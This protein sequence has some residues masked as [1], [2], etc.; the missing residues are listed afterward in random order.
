MQAVTDIE[1][2]STEDKPAI[3]RR[4]AVRFTLL[5]LLVLTFG[6]AVGLGWLRLPGASSPEALLAAVSAF[7]AIGLAQQAHREFRNAGCEART[8]SPAPAVIAAYSVS[9]LLLGCL[10]VWAVN[11]SIRHLYPAE[12]WRVGRTADAF[13]ETAIGLGII[14]AY[15]LS[16]GTTLR[17]RPSVW[18]RTIGLAVVPLSAF[19]TSWVVM[20]EMMVVSLVGIAI[21]GVQIAEPTRWA[22]HPFPSLQPPVKLLDAFYVRGAVT[23]AIWSAGALTTLAGAY[24]LHRS[25]RAR[26]GFFAAA[27][28]CF[29][30]V[31]Y[32]LVWARQ[33][34]PEVLPFM[35]DG[36]GTLPWTNWLLA[37]SIIVMASALGS[38][39]LA[40]ERETSTP[41]TRST[42]T[43]NNG[44]HLNPLVIGLGILGLLWQWWNSAEL[45]YLFGQSLSS[46]PMEQAWRVCSALG[47]GLIEPVGIL[48]VAIL[49]V[50]TG[51]L[52]RICRK[53]GEGRISG[54][55]LEPSRFLT[56][57]LFLLAAVSL[58]PAV[59][60]WYGTA[61]LFLVRGN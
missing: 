17:M 14:W 3:A 34:L 40:A 16:L 51:T 15:W 49:S 10:V 32:L 46:S 55:S 12:D 44:W 53:P 43:T 36:V 6:V 23:A 60:A 27:M 2:D 33:V 30:I 39:R 42:G 1:L 7:I 4:R 20:S 57:W 31:L 35:A 61:I 25:G 9:S 5:D 13:G 41:E 19:Y 45:A 37:I 24:C 48:R 28:V 21:Q 47:Y 18:T 56:T 11:R 26:W 50:L 29:L 8:W 22:G 54:W 38:W 59:F 52:W 58:V